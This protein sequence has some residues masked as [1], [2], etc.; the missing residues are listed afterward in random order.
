MEFA[1]VCL[2]FGGCVVALVVLDDGLFL[3]IDPDD[4]I[5]NCLFAK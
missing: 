5:S 4:M 2:M 3:C 1:L